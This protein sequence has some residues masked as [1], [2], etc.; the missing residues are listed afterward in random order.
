MRIVDS[1]YINN[2]YLN[3]FGFFKKGSII[4]G[5]ILSYEGDT[6]LIDI[7]GLGIIKATTVR[8]LK[9]YIDNEVT[10]LV[11]SDNPKEIQLKLILDN[12]IDSGPMV[13]VQK[14]KNYLINILKRFGVKDDYISVEF[15]DNLIKYRIEVNKE[16]LFDGI[17]ILDKLKQIIDI[18]NGERSVYVSLLSDTREEVLNIKNVDL[19]NILINDKANTDLDTSNH[20]YVNN[21]FTG[22]I[23]N[24]LIKTIAFFIKYKI[25]PTINNIEHFIELNEK[26]EI[27]SKDYELLKNIIDKEF[28]NE[29]KN[30]MIG[31]EKPKNLIEV[32]YEKYIDNLDEIFNLVKR[33]SDQVINK[34][35]NVV[36]DL[37]D[38]INLIK[39]LNNE[40]VFIYLPLDFKKDL[41]NGVITL[42][43]K[44]KK[45]NNYKENINIFINLNTNNLG[46]VKITCQIS[47]AKMSIKFGNVKDEDISLFRL[48]E[49][50][51]KSMVKDIGYEIVNITYSK[52]EHDNILDTL[53][54]D[55][56]P[57][58]YFDVKV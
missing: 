46:K 43:K 30:I 10:F 4:S 33:R 1:L 5:K 58:Y 50:E 24:N 54:V 51:L 41:Y 25:K 14:S 16:N 55:P 38:K 23:D 56:N 6:A 39:E 36:E 57:I 35:D 32:S 22:K 8:E 21:L 34:K 31:N 13:D 19:R 7:K 12:S 42:L 26:P 45:K 40:L 9:N 49:S 37:I 48:R 29:N 2:Q 44:R 28:T 47:N 18:E 20:I 53:I 17:N 11:K 27:F 52:D 15:L 3:K